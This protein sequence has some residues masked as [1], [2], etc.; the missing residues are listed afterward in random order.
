MVYG[1]DLNEENL[2]L[3]FK[4]WVNVR[5]LHFIRWKF[6]EIDNSFTLSLPDSYRLVSLDFYRSTLELDTT[7]K[8]LVNA[9]S[10][11]KSVLRNL[12]KVNA[13]GFKDLD[14]IKTIFESYGFDVTITWD[15]K[16][17]AI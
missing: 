16:C 3:I 12:K 10:S 1:F 4:C 15:G 9:L 13:Y 2:K 5:N 14:K 7:L 17:D 11:N 8:Y 6:F